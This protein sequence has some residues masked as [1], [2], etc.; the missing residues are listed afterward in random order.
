MTSCTTDERTPE[1]SVSTLPA[2]DD[3]ETS[4]VEDEK[5]PKGDEPF[6]GRQRIPAV[7]ARL[8]RTIL[9]DGAPTE[10]DANV[11]GD[12]YGALWNPSNPGEV[13]VRDLVSGAEVYRYDAGGAPRYVGQ[14]RFHGDTAALADVTAIDQEQDAT[15]SRL[16]H[17]D[18]ATGLETQVPPPEGT[19]WTMWPGQ[20]IETDS[21]FAW[22][23]RQLDESGDCVVAID[24]RDDGTVEDRTLACW[25]GQFSSFT[26]AS[27]GGLSALLF[28]AGA[29][30][31]D[32]R[33]RRYVNLDD[34]GDLLIGDDDTCRPY[35]GIVID[36]WQLWSHV[37]PSHPEQIPQSALIADGPDGKE[38]AFGWIVSGSLTYCGE[39]AYWYVEESDP[40]DPNGAVHSL[41]RWAPGMP[42]AE[43]LD[44]DRP[45]EYTSGGIA[46]SGRTVTTQ[47]LNHALA[48]PTQLTYYFR[49]T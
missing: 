15:S 16:V 7:D 27:T 25:P 43:I 17:V 11:A 22:T 8:E 39:H 49:P 38:L 35:D 29:N 28:P 20:L 6:F 40:S 26:A 18:L 46:C 1:Q 3:Q 5:F 45:G 30:V 14:V 4:A 47:E 19:R 44:A 36:G 33:Q 34:G 21:G 12:R 32:C 37:S 24:V 31:N 13:A 42:V 41:R 9:Y 2:I 48:Q 23:V 10:Y